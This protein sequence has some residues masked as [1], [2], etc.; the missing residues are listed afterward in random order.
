MT[1]G[2]SVVQELVS[3]AI[4][5]NVPEPTLVRIRGS[6][7]VTLIS[8]AA[9]PSSTF[10]VMGIKLASA[11]AVT[12]ASVEQPLAQI[13]SDWIWWTVVPLVLL[14][15]GSVASPNGDGLNSNVR[16]PVDSKAM[17]KVKNNE[18]LVL[19]MQNSVSESTTTVGVDGGVRCLFK[20]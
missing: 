5:E 15:G 2:A 17:R 6:I 1:T 18:L 10:M 13:G 12:G 8:S 11:A 19:V 3:E 20:R 14:T 4:L 9:V 16:V 7:L